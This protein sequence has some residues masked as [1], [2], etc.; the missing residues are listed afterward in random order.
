VLSDSDVAHAFSLIHAALGSPLQ[1]DQ[2]S[3]QHQLIALQ[4]LPAA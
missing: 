3:A 2:A 4:A 1:H